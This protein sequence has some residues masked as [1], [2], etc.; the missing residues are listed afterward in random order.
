MAPSTF[1][2]LLVYCLGLGALLLALAPQWQRAQADDIAQVLIAEPPVSSHHLAP[3][4]AHVPI[5]CTS[6]CGAT[7]KR[8]ELVTLD[9][10]RMIK[11]SNALDAAH[12]SVFS[13]RVLLHLQCRMLLAS[14]MPYATIWTGSIYWVDCFDKYVQGYCSAHVTSRDLK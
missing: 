9:K 12:T 7:R 1:S 6:A 4:P 14:V 3:A 8:V 5:N 10:K 11:N 2:A 13:I